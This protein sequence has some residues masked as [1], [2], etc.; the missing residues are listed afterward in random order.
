M[1]F[2]LEHPHESMWDVVSLDEKGSR[3]GEDVSTLLDAAYR[4]I[5]GL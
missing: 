2:D 1:P 3:E 4:S 5:Y